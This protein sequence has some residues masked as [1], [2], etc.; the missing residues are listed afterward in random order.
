ML[1]FIYG[2]DEYQIKEKINELKSGFKEKKD[3]SGLN[4]ISLSGESF[5][6]DSFKQEALTVPFLSDSKLIIVEGLLSNF[7]AGQKKLQEEVVEFLKEKE[8]TIKNSL[9]FADCYEN[10]KKIPE[11]NTLFNFLSKQK[12][13]WQLNELKGRDLENW[14][15]KLLSLNNIKM[16]REALSELIVLVGNDL[17]QLTLELNKL[18]AYKNFGLI[19]AADVKELTKA[20]FDED[21]FKLTDALGM[22]NQSLALKL[23]SDQLQAGNQPLGVLPMITR[24]FR[25]FLQLKGLLKKSSAYPNKSQLARQLGLHEYVVQK[26]L[27]QIKNFSEEQLKN[28]YLDLLQI[29]KQLKSGT[30]NPELLFD[31]FIIKNC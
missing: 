11:K 9:I 17:R 1:F 18:S 19:T 6:L 23:I 8:V 13:C 14:L 24:Q 7:S 10:T 28:I 25:I 21:I 3:R 4:V 26:S 31:L 27:G 12:F 22:R 16:E 30:K 5:D 20:R 15:K 29:E 2:T